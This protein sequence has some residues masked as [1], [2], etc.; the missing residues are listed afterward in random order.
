MIHY[1]FNLI[2]P[3]FAPARKQ[4]APAV[5]AGLITGGASLLGSIFGSSSSSSTARESLA[6]QQDFAREENEK[7]RQF[8]RE[9]LG[10][11]Q[12]Y[13]TSM[14]NQ[15]NFYNS[16]QEQVKRYIQAGLN[17]NLMF[18]GGQTAGNATTGIAPSQSGS[19]TSR[20]P[21]ASLASEMAA[22]AQSR[23]AFGDFLNQ[24][25]DVVGKSIDNIT[26]MQ[27]NLA[28]LEKT[29][30]QSQ[31]FHQQRR[32]IIQNMHINNALLPYQTK[33]LAAASE[34][35]T[36]QA[37]TQVS[38]RA[39]LDAQAALNRYDLANIKPQE[40]E[41]LKKEIW[42]IGQQVAI[43]RLSA[44][45]AIRQAQAAM[46]SANASAEYQGVV[47]PALKNWYQTQSQYTHFMAPY[48]AYNKVS[49][50]WG[51]VRAFDMFNDYG[52]D[53][54]PWRYKA[55]WDNYNNPRE[56]PLYHR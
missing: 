13:A 23:S 52:I 39:V 16:P 44:S 18:E 28:E 35:Q 14:W 43:G 32:E 50:G 1:D 48:D 3:N 27:R 33:N 46:T 2:N 36:Q 40:F 26:R 8:Q 54:I 24:I 15:Q 9:M 5:A 17:P 51:S 56:K 53:D 38:Q 42:A 29:R 31:L 34:L 41:K 55:P 10:N 22:A 19:P 21:S 11:Q 6:M 45:A 47:G 49:T 20:M 25:S 30:G 37:L 12:D 7:D 4:I